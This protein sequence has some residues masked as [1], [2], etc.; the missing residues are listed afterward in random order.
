MM[1]KKRNPKNYP[2]WKELLALLKKEHIIQL[3]VKGKGEEKL[4]KDFRRDLSLG[5]IKKLINECDFWISVDNFF[6][7]LAHHVLKPGVVIFGKSDP[8]IFGYPENINVLKDRKYI[9]KNQFALWEE[10][11][12]NEEVFVKPDLIIKNIKLISNNIK[13]K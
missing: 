5:E 8:D 3:G 1:N 9:R 7:H 12:Y 6:P 11:P 10:E 13:N 2:Y 4:T